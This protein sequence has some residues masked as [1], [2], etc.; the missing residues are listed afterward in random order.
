MELINH[1]PE[2]TATRRFP[3]NKTLKVIPVGDLHIGA[4]GFNLERL[5]KTIEH[6]VKEGAWFIGMGDY[7]DFVSESNRER[8]IN[9]G[10]YD[11]ARTIIDDAADKILDKIKDAL[12]PSRGRWLGVLEGNHY[13]LYESGVT[14]DVSLAAYLKAPFLGTCGL[15]QVRMIAPPRES[16]TCSFWAHH[17]Y[18]PGGTGG[19]VLTKLHRAMEAFEADVCL[20]AHYHQ[21]VTHKVSRLYATVSPNP[22]ILG[23]PKLLVGTGSFMA[24]YEQG[25]RYAGR[26]R[27]SYVER[28]MLPPAALGSPFITV[29]VLPS[30]PL[31][32]DLNVT[33]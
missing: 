10:L 32:L 25:S 7:C 15:V 6:G 24:G 19:A 14:T 30:K 31:R 29:N 9:A 16:I 28:R 8:L 33:T 1:D 3:L 22:R 18:G 2:A 12:A 11:T 13:Y 21:L 23:K 5:A 27:G 17:G 20:M 4:D 26:S